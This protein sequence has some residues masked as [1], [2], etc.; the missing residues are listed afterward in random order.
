MQI[1]I[2]NQA[3]TDLF[4]EA[5]RDFHDVCP[6]LAREL[7]Q[8]VE[9]Q[10]RA[11]RR[12]NG[13]SPEGHFMIS[14][15]IPQFLFDIVLNEARKRFGIEDVWKDPRNFRLFMKIWKKAKVKKKPTPFYDPKRSER[16]QS[17]STSLSASAS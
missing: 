4:E 14:G 16:C 6:R 2:K 3:L 9:E 7:N 12:T 17:P 15:L 13:M 5:V 10:S 11:L 8:A 1:Q